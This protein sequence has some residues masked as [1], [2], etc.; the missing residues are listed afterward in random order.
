MNA[1][2]VVVALAAAGST[3]VEGALTAGGVLQSRQQAGA[4]DAL[5]HGR[6]DVSR[7]FGRF[8]AEA[9]ASVVF[10]GGGLTP[11]VGLSDLGSR[12]SVGYRPVGFVERVS[13]EVMPFNPLLRL[14]SFDWANVWGRPTFLVQAVT[15]VLT[16]ELATKA[17]TVWLSGRFKQVLNPL[18][19]VNELSVDPIVGLEL[20]LP[21]GLKLEARFGWFSYGLN[22][23]LGSLGLEVPLNGGGGGA[24]LSWTWN[25]AVGP[26]IDLVTYR[27]DPLRFER[28]FASEPRRAPFAAQLT[29]EAGAGAEHLADPG[30]FGKGKTQPMAWA[31]LQARIRL[32]DVRL[33]ATARVHSVTFSVFDFHGLPP[34]TA[35][36]RS[37]TQSAPLVAGYLGADWTIR[38]LRLTPGLL[39]RVTQ[40]GW[41]R[42]PAVAPGGNNPVPGAGVGEWRTSAIGPD[43]RVST[44]YGEVAPFIAAK[45]SARWEVLSFASVVAEVDVEKDL[46]DYR[47]P[48]VGMGFQ[49]QT[50]QITVMGQLYLQARF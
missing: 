11:G 25:E 49:P 43:L 8:F 19:Q 37:V 39:F 2:V 13:L 9:H 30:T 1:W 26:A 16:A 28:F 4:V 20:P 21:S 12:F 40:Y 5:I 15:P 6:L 23:T 42:F 41:L 7:D 50:D 17:F 22:P 35:L 14:P 45:V 18:S 27:N 46:N 33:F 44:L 36:D 47:V 24:R 38:A 29:L 31:D 34:F 3:E 10:R 32:R 48:V